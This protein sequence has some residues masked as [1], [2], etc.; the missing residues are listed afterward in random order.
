MPELIRLPRPLRDL[1]VGSRHGL[2]DGC[3]RAWEA[4][5]SAPTAW[6]AVD[7]LEFVRAANTPIVS[8]QLRQRENALDLQLDL[9]QQVR[10]IA[11]AR[12]AIVIM[13]SIPQTLMDA[14]LGAPLSALVDA[15]LF[16][17]PAIRI[18][19]IIARTG[20]PQIDVRCR[21]PTHA[22]QLD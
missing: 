16:E 20:E 11:I 13:P 18:E 3:R 22:V 21:C 12:R 5:S 6:V 9:A 8:L 14:A 7:P 1:L 10:A 19:R 15:P 17:S 2:A 4:A